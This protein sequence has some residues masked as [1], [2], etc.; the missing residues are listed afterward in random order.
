MNWQNQLQRQA[1]GLQG[2]TGAYGQAGQQGNA[3]GQN[4]IGAL[5]TGEQ[6]AN[7]A[8]QAGAVPYNA[9]MTAGMQPFNAA[10]AY[11]GAQGGVNQGYGN[12]LSSII[13]YLNSSKGPRIRRCV[14]PAANRAQQF[15]DR[16]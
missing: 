2:M 16:T 1:T 9:A 11:T 6:A 4:L 7:Y 13:P 10:N 15:H 3:V 12:I 8:G 14:R 5:G